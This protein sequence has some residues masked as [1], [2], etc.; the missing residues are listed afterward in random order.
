MNNKKAFALGTLLLLIVQIAGFTQEYSYFH[1]YDLEHKAYLV[2]EPKAFPK[3]GIHHSKVEA[4]KLPQN[5][6]WRFELAKTINEK[7]YYY[8]V[9]RLYD[10]AIAG[11]DS[12]DGDIYAYDSFR[13][14]RNAQW[15]ATEET[16]AEGQI[17][18]VF[19]DRKHDRDLV[20]GAKYDG[21]IYH[22]TAGERRNARW[23]LELVS[24]GKKGPDFFV[25]EQRLINLKFHTDKATVITE[26]PLLIID[27]SRLNNSEV[28]QSITLNK[29]KSQT[30]EESWSFKQAVK[31]SIYHELSVS[32]GL[33]GTA[34]VKST[35]TVGFE[36]EKEWSESNKRI[37]KN[38]LVWNIPVVIPPHSKLSVS[39]VITSLKRNIPFTATILNELGSGDEK[40]MKVEGVWSG[41]QYV[42]GEI[43][44]DQTNL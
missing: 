43:R 1:I 2:S 12:Y 44:F 14:K 16:V 3:P 27:E 13:G 30:V 36:Y 29:E 32:S 38:S 33:A 8:I 37:V 10:T 41:V 21:E 24:K 42:T 25:V 19:T 40:E 4:M 31:V 23:V 7:K 18:F 39:G 6:Q 28:A 20:A 22:Q 26:E 9:D 15:T 35:T 5:A 17:P 11:G 34:E